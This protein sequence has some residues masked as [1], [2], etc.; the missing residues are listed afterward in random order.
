MIAGIDEAGRG[1][2]AGPVVA[3]SVILPSINPIVGLNDSKKLSKSKRKQLFL[4]ITEEAIAWSFATASSDEIDRI[5]IL[6][7]TKLAMRR[8]FF[9]L[10]VQPDKVLVDGRDVIDIPVS[11]EAIV[12]GDQKEPSI[13]AASIVA[14]HMRDLMMETLA[15]RCPMYGF[16]AHA[17]YPTKKHKEM[18][19]IHGITPYHR[20]TFCKAK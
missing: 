11:C 7:A 10:R 2:L 17:G 14:K 9:A 12:K 3:A 16:E 1:P 13:M 15:F 8:S 6:Q 20:K 18:I 5:N 4:E 19:A